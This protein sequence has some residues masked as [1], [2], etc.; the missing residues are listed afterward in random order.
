MKKEPN[1][2]GFTSYCVFPN[3]TP[4]TTPGL[5]TSVPWSM[6]A[7]PAVSFRDVT[8]SLS[9]PLS[10]MHERTHTHAQS[11]HSTEGMISH[12]STQFLELR[13]KANT[14]IASALPIHIL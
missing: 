4:D 2:K 9:R 10:P 3:L 11:I 12:M 8:V 14:G 7:P 6:K 5:S 1:P 13:L